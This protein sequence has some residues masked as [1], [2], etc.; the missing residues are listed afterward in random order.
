MPEY[1]FCVNFWS[2]LNIGHSLKNFG[3]KMVTNTT[4]WTQVVSLACVWTAL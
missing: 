3:G 2:F 1:G 4:A